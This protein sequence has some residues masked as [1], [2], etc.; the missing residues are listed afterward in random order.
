MKIITTVGT[1]LIG[2]SG[3]DCSNLENERFLYSLFD[4]SKESSIKNNIDK[5]EREIYNCINQ[6]SDPSIASAELASLKKIDPSDQA[7]VYLFC[8]ETVLSYMCGRVLQKYLGE[9]A[10]IQIIEGLQVKILDDFKKL[11][12]P[13]LLTAI[14]KIAHGGT[15][16]DDIVLNVTG[17]YKAI[18][19]I[20]TVIGQ[21]KK[22][23]TY[24]LF[25][26][27]EDKK[28]ELIEIPKM[29]VD[30]QTN[31]FDTYWEIF[32]RFGVKGEEF[33]KKQTLANNF[34]TTC[35]GFL[36]IVDDIV[37]LNPVG[38]ILWWNC[39]QQY[40]ILNT[41]DSIW[42][43]IQKQEDIKRIL[44]SKLHN[45]EIRLRKTER[46]QDHYVFDDGNNNNRIYYFEEM[47]RLYVYK[48]FQ[49]EEQARLYINIPFQ[50]AQRVDFIQKSKSFRIPIKR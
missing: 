33:Q 34:L 5:K 28:Y 42:A 38:K 24:Y 45:S 16:W 6:E 39:Q 10:K 9:R 18:I 49:N 19:P 23:P 25:K 43:E 29:P 17:G 36:E 30:Y 13:N 47:G 35:D 22:L 8:T 27:E 21:I 50:E 14:E 2:N 31:V 41:T 20:M 37:T 4:G 1:S 48:T 7:E 40:F 26:G 44:E 12:V 11:G 15:Y 32:S 3:I 46:K